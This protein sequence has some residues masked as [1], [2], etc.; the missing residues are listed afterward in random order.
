MFIFSFVHKVFK[1]ETLILMKSLIPN[2]GEILYFF[3]EFFNRTS[4][5][6]IY[7]LN[8]FYIFKKYLDLHFINYISVKNFDSILS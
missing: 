3:K 5:Y 4:V 8:N 2:F 7:I 1:F 6:E